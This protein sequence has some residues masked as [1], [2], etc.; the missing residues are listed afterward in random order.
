[1]RKLR[2][3]ITELPRNQV[4]HYNE[5]FHVDCGK[6]LAGDFSDLV[7]ELVGKR[8]IMP[9]EAGYRIVQEIKWHGHYNVIENGQDAPCYRLF[10]STGQNHALGN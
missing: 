2:L 10:L 7:D 5:T 9:S 8:F 4:L 1:M 6:I 3:N